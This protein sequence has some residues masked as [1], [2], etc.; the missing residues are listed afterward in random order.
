MNPDYFNRPHRQI[1]WADM[2]PRQR[3]V[4]DAPTQADLDRL[5]AM[6]QNKLDLQE[7]PIK[8]DPDVAAAPSNQSLD[9]YN[10]GW[11]AELEAQ[12]KTF[13]GAVKRIEALPLT[14][15]GVEIAKELDTDAIQFIDAVDKSQGRKLADAAHQL[16][17]FHTGI[18]KRLKAGPESVRSAARSFLIR[19]D[20]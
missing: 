9:V 1:T 16:H 20:Q 13:D 2:Y 15:Q 7:R 19:F 6:E 14:R 11:S 5:D 10:K 4:S 8:G 3:A 18:L 12:G 17:I